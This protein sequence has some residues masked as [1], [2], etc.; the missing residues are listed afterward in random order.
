MSGSPVTLGFFE[1][2]GAQWVF[3]VN[4]SFEEE[5]KT[6]ATLKAPFARL[7]EVD[8]KSGALVELARPS[9]SEGYE[10]TLAPGD[11]RLFQVSQ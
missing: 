10:L 1:G 8:K 11:G 3:I 7:K 9:G 5:A 6:T 4:R 2:A